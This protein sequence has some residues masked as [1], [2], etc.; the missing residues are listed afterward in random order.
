MRRS[1]ALLLTCLLFSTGFTARRN[2]GGGTP[3]ITDFPDSLRSVYL[4]TEGIKRATIGGDTTGAKRLFREAIAA[5]PAHAPSYYELAGCEVLTQGDSAL[6]HARRAH[7]LDTLNK[8][9]LQ[10]YGQLLVM[11]RRY[12]DAIPVYRRMMRRDP[13]DPDTYRMLALLYEQAQLPFS[14]IAVLDSAEVRFGR[15]GVL[16][17]NKRRL[18]IA[19]RQYDKALA[20]AQ[21]MVD[22]VP[23]EIEHRIA[24]GELYGAMGRDSLA[25]VEFDEARRIDSTDVRMLISLADFYNER[26][27]YRNFL[28]VSK[29]LFESDEI[30]LA[31]KLRRFDIL[32]SDLRFYQDNYFQINDIAS[33]LIIKYPDEKRVVERYATHLITTGQIDRALEVYK[34]HTRDLPPEKSYWRMVID[35]ESYKQRHDSVELYV[36]RALELFPGDPDLYVARGHVKSLANDEKEAVKS[37][38]EA[39]RLASTD[40]LRGEIWG[41]IGDL[42]HRTGKLKKCFDAYD[43]SLRYY[44]DN[45]MVLNNYAY[46]LSEKEGRTHGELQQALEMSSRAIALAENN[47]TYLDTYAW[48]LFRLGRTAEAKKSMQQAISLDRRNNPEL[49]LHYGDILHALGE[50]FLAEVYW[51]KALENGYEDPDAIAARIEEAK[52]KPSE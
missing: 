20:E 30:P 24:L 11:N 27:Q 48:V 10:L 36:T 18:L 1:I 22:A 2:D 13:K 6:L 9:Y 41:Y 34:L 44:R 7:E 47:P 26:Q 45:P 4:Y 39:I 25:L 23:Y 19:T 40:S 15:I 37:Y 21:A 28:S 38:R 43:R 52:R 46:F 29:Q 5:D 17:D 51:R 42:Y 14:A 35:I 50:R 3:S 49:F 12:D 8:W 33:S 16:S 32:T 31:E